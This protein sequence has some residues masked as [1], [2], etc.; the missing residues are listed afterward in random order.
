MS[1]GIK[2]QESSQKEAGV[3]VR[4]VLLICCDCVCVTVIRVLPSRWWGQS[5]ISKPRAS[6]A[7]TKLWERRLP[8][9][10]WNRGILDHL[11]TCRSRLYD[12]ARSNCRI[13]CWQKSWRECWLCVSYEMN[14]RS[15]SICGQYVG[16]LIFWVYLVFWHINLFF[17]FSIN[18]HTLWKRR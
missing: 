5:C 4:D 1:Y 10:T 15:G 3:L 13:R 8:W 11:A 17:F 6:T 18:I 12:P 2:Y 16:S 7:P 9:S 14:N